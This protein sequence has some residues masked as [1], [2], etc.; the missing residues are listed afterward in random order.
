MSKVDDLNEK[1][2]IDAND[3]KNINVDGTEANDNV[4]T[5]YTVL[6]NGERIV[7]YTDTWGASLQD[8]L[9]GHGCLLYTSDAAD[10]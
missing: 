6:V 2:K 3:E 9:E 10:E 4:D 7:L 8:K 1:K 5:R